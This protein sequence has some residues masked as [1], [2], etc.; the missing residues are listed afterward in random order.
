MSRGAWE[1]VLPKSS[2]P[3]GRGLTYSFANAMTTR[4]RPAVVEPLRCIGG[5]VVVLVA[6]EG[7]VGHHDSRTTYL[8][9]GPVVREIDPVDPRRSHETFRREVRSFTKVADSLPHKPARAE[10]ADETDEISVSRIDK[11]QRWLVGLCSCTTCMQASPCITARETSGPDPLFWTTWN[12]QR[13]RRPSCF[14]CS[15]C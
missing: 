11:L 7:C 1:F 12:G 6:E 10:V 13:R 3:D 9:E 14:A 15:T 2:W 4:A 8:P 5:L